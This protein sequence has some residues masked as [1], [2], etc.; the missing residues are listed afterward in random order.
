MSVGAILI[1]LSW[2]G[3]GSRVSCY[4]SI[5]AQ[6]P[7]RTRPSV[8]AVER[9]KLGLDTN[10][11]AEVKA[12]IAGLNPGFV[13][14]QPLVLAL[15]AE[16]CRPEIVRYLLRHGANA[17]ARDKQGRTALMSVTRPD[18]ASLLLANG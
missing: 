18:V 3:F 12:A 8:S 16:N 5:G 17:K 15:A 14:G 9:L 6:R 1:C 7:A 2:A 4:G 11:F 13:K 10:N